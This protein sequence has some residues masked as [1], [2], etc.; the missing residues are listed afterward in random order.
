MALTQTSVTCHVFPALGSW[1][2][3][4]LTSALPEAVSV[5]DPVHV[6]LSLLVPLLDPLLASPVLGVGDLGEWVGGRT[7]IGGFSGPRR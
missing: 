7:G 4:T 5:S 3:V 6:L 1:S 2:S